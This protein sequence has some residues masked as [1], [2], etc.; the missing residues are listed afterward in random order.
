MAISSA[1]GASTQYFGHADYEAA[2]RQGYTP[3]EVLAYL[4]RNQSL[5]QGNN[6][7]GRG[8]L[9]D[10]IREQVSAAFYAQQGAGSTGTST[11][12]PSLPD[13]S[14]QLDGGV[15]QDAI[16]AF[17]EEMEDA[18][19][20]QRRQERRLLRAQQTQAS[21]AARAGQMAQFKIGTQTP[22]GQTGGTGQFKRRLQIKPVTSSALSIGAASSNKLPGTNT[23]LNV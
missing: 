20:A 13:Y 9:Y 12:T 5:L 23:M 15:D 7:K 14:D 19:K 2:L 3:N 21:N 4:E 10:Q 22:S 1:Y 11:S 8:G 17:R 6:Q 18:R 16:D